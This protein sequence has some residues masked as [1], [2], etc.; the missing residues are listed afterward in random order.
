MNDFDSHERGR[1][2]GRAGAYQRSFARLCAYPAELVLDAAGVRAGTAVL[3]VGTGPGTLAALAVTRGAKVAAVD[4]EPSMVSAAGHL[5]PQVRLGALPEL[6]FA[7]EEFDAVV[8][9]FVLNHVGA[10]VDAVRELAR[11]TRPGGRVA[12]TIWPYPQPP[13]QRLWGDALAAAGVA[14]SVPAR[15]PATDFERT[16]AG[17]TG[18]LGTALIEVRA[19]RVEWVHR[20]DP[21]DW[22]SGPANGIGA[23]GEILERL[24]PAD[25]AA[26]R[27]AYAELTTDFL[28]DDGLL[29]LPT[30]AL[31][32]SAVKPG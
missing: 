5:V 10:P 19:A 24:S 32:G 30:A 4:P 22:W 14:S 17:L 18:L 9:G 20:A 15:R 6:P 21:D 12:V 31:L 29:G 23:I 28:G 1:W 2:T 7:A 25:V 26:V 27:A 13:L 3:D 11:V 8:A 16:P